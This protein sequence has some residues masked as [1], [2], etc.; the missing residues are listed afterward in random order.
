MDYINFAFLSIKKNAAA[1]ILV[2]L[3]FAA[4]LLTVNFAVSTI[5]DR[6]MLSVPFKEI[7]N[8]KTVYADDWNFIEKHIEQEM[9]QRQSRQVM[10]DEITGDYKIYDILHFSDSEYTVIS[11][12]DEIYSRLKMPLVSGSYKTA[13][14]TFGTSLGEHTVTINDLTLTLNISGNLTQSTFLPMMSSFSTKGFT[15]KDI[16]EVSINQPNVIVTNRSSI[17]GFEEKFSVSSGFFITLESDYEGN[18]KRLTQAGAMVTSKD[19]IK[20]N[21]AALTEDIRSFIP[22]IICVLLIVIIGTVTISVIINRQNEYRNGVMW[23][24]GYSKRQIL[25]AHGI[26]IFV[27]LIVS[28]AVGAAVFGVMKVVGIELAVTMNLTVAN[29]ITSVIL[30]GILLVISLIIPAAK[31][32]KESPVEYI[33]RA[34]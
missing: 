4:L 12:S 11:V 22:V 30:C 10:L 8:D 16:F 15:A 13:V 29:L 1:F 27:I 17:S 28:A 14:G 25:F 19:I 31:I 7:L 20:N 24:C 33:G 23:L 6:Q 3:E 2:I 5:N 34:K 26:N 9:N 21:H 32:A 18:C